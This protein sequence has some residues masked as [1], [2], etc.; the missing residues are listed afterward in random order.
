MRTC[1]P[2]VIA[3]GCTAFWL[4][5]VAGQTFRSGINLVLCQV[6][7]KDV[8]GRV[9]TGLPREE[10]TVFEDETERRIGQFSSGREPVSLGILVDTSRS[11]EGRRFDDGQRALGK[12]LERF[13][14]E[15]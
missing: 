6:T 1:V 13:Q 11:M 2:L 3:L 15:D 10:F 8:A 9:V 14:A 4:V 12:L 5:D 7:V